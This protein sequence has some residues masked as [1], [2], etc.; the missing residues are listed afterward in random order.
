MRGSGPLAVET[1][2]QIPLSRPSPPAA[3]E[4]G[5]V[6]DFLPPTTKDRFVLLADGDNVWVR[7][8]PTTAGGDADPLVYDVFDRTSALID[9]VRV[10]AGRTIVGFS[11][12]FAY[13]VWHDA[14]VVR[15]EK[16]RIR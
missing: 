8:R 15:I 10:P 7:L 5:E 11:P 1:T 16:A 4:R 13:L 12:G 9:R 14:G 3:I 2:I 6:P